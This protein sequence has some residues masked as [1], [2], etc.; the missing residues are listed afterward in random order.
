MYGRWLTVGLLVL[1]ARL[2][3]AQEK[4]EEVPPPGYFRLI[5]W[6]GDAADLYYLRGDKKVAVMISPFAK[7]SHYA[8][9]QNG[10]VVFLKDVPVADGTRQAT[11]VG[12][13]TIRPDWKYP[14]LVATLAESGLKFSVYN[15]DPNQFG[16]GQIRLINTTKEPVIAKL[17][18][19]E[20][21][22]APEQVQTTDL[23][24]KEAQ[25]VNVELWV[26]AN[27]KKQPVYLRGWELEPTMRIT[28]FITKDSDGRFR[29]RR[30]R[31][32]DST[33]LPKKAEEKAP[34]QPVAQ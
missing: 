27:G 7:S 13:V 1:G 3:W 30:L 31:E 12:R 17:A 8:L 4:K 22:L 2:A 10:T 24:P 5:S 16:A 20:V 15:E 25:V 19:R 23:Q 6:E 18:D 14:L 26:E 32:G 33:F 28:A 34:V 11:Q 9:P 29:V 21:K